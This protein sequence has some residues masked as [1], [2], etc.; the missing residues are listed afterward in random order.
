MQNVHK[1]SLR[2]IFQVVEKCAN[3]FGNPRINDLAPLSGFSG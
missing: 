3:C 1:N 2:Y